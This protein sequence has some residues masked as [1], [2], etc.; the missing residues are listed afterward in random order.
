VEGE[1]EVSERCTLVKVGMDATWIG[2][3]DVAFGAEESGAEGGAQ[4]GR[5]DGGDAG[6]GERRRRRRPEVKVRRGGIERG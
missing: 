6:N 1:K 4:G 2:V 5:E 3:V